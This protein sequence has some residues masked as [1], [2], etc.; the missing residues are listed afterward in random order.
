[1]NPVLL[2]RYAPRQP[3]VQQQRGIAALGTSL[4]L[5]V[6]TI[7]IT[8]AAAQVSSNDQRGAANEVRAQESGAVGDSGL[9]RGLSYLRQNVGQIRSTAAG[10]WMNAGNVKW[11]PCSSSST[12]APCGNGT[13]NVFDN[14][15]TAYSNVPN[16]KTSTETPGTFFTHFVARATTPGAATP[17]GGVFN[18]VSEGRSSDGLGKSLIRQSAVFQ[19]VLAHR[20]DAPLI[21][22]GTIGLSGTISIVANPNGGGTGVPLSAWSSTNITE[23]G[24][25]QTCHVWEYLSTGTP[26]GTQTD[27]DGDMVTLCPA[28]SCPN[29][30]DQTLSRKDVEGIDVLD[31]DGNV[32]A[33][34]DSPYFPP[35]LFEYTFGVSEASW[36]T[37]ESQAQVIT[38]CSTLNAS[39]AGLI[40]VNGDCSIPSNSI[41]GSLEAPVILVV[42]NGSFQMNANGQFFG[43]LFAFAH[44]GGAIDVKLNGGPTLY[45]SMI[46]NRNID[47]GNGNYTARYDKGVLDNL[48]NA[49]GPASRIAPIAGSWRN[50]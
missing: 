6:V 23:T 27:S 40:W 21:A 12:T 7:L 42:A 29:S 28:C 18:V 20:P 31:V 17:S 43:V 4:A 33:N 30:V 1:M 48:G 39:S 25:M 9:G 46:S 16:L 44:D 11:A 8:L 36:R 14:S 49:L 38:D 10:G 47:T 32:G 19:P 35:D 15:W 26:T 22:A 3:A 13:S 37:V 2:G 5:L 24:S 34:P 45:G 50:Y 41:V